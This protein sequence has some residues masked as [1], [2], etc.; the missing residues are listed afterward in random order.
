MPRRG[1]GNAFL[2]VGG[3]ELRESKCIRDFV[4]S[5]KFVTRGSVVPDQNQE[6]TTMKLDV[7]VYWSIF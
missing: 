6:A 3:N 4:P 1:R 7:A 2:Y 5:R